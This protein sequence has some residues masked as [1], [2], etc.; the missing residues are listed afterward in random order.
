MHQAFL[1]AICDNPSDDT[2]RLIYA[3]WLED[4]GQPERAEFIRLQIE[5][6]GVPARDPRRVD[7]G[8]RARALLRK[9]ARSWFAPPKGWRPD[10]PYQVRRG[11]PDA[12]IRVAVLDLLEHADDLFARWPITRLHPGAQHLEDVTSVLAT[13]PWLA[14]VRELVLSECHT[15]PEV[16]QKLIDSPHL[17]NLT[18]LHVGGCS[19]ND[20]GLR[21]LAAL[22]HLA[23]LRELDIRHNRITSEGFQALVR[24]PYRA[25]TRSLCLSGNDYTVHDFVALLKSPGWPRLT[26]LNLWYTR[27]GDGGLEELAA[28]P[29]LAK[30]TVLNL[31]NNGI[32]DR[33]LQALAAS[34]HA[35]NLHTLSLALNN[36]S[37][38]AADILRDSAALQGLTSL[39]LYRTPNLHWRARKRLREHFGQHVSFEQPW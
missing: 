38:R 15:G 33:G 11:F 10:A 12:L 34:P 31:N 23:G 5:L 35:G 28:C 25:S 2:P 22:P 20:E 6:H 16:F 9:Y 3:D 39:N 36:L 14:R 18:S 21:H 19:L 37:S 1:Q 27:L 4:N 32:T 8:K 29:E 30:L 17:V 13:S 24:S 7:G 26:D